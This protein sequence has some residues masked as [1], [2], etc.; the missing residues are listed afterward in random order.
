MKDVTI[1]NNWTFELGVGDG[2]DVPI[3]VIVGFMQRDQFSQHN[4]NNDTF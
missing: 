4:Q 1:E 2:F 3:Y